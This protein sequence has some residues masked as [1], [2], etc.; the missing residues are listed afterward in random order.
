[1]TIITNQNTD[2]TEMIHQTLPANEYLKSL[3]TNL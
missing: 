3:M 1:M 2:R